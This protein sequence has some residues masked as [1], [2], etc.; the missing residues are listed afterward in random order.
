VLNSVISLYYYFRLGMAMYFKEPT[1]ESEAHYSPAF[2]LLLALTIIGLA[3]LLLGIYPHPFAS[4]ARIS[5]IS[6]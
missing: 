5:A 4:W 6:F 3:I 1:Q 2:S